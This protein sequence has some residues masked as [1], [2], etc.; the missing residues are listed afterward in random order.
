VY[1]VLRSFHVL[2]AI[3]WFGAV[4]FSNFVVIP[5]LLAMPHGA[6]NEFIKAFTPKLDNTMIPAGTLTI[7]TGVAVGLDSGVWGQLDT[8]YGL[9]WIAAFVVATLTF[10][11][12]L[13]VISP[14]AAKLHALPP[15]S[16]AALSQTHRVKGLA[17]L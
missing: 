6:Q 12:G 11:W 13:F 3:F 10:L 17:M 5:A 15:G 2:F 1:Q 8:A 9:T 14:N 4:M 16:T 7:L